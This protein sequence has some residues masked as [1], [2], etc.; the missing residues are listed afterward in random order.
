MKTFG[1]EFSTYD[2]PLKEFDNDAAEFGLLTHTG[3]VPTAGTAIDQVYTHTTNVSALS[4]AWQDTGLTGGT[5]PTGVYL[6]H[7]ITQDLE[8][9]SGTMSW[10]GAATTTTTT[11]EV[12]LHR[13]GQSGT[14]RVYLRIARTLGS[15]KLQM[16]SATAITQSTPYELTFRRLL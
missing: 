3:L 9:Y 12:V 10:F 6:V 15:M 16:A 13:A 11:D 4:S 7:L 1:N 14:N 8:C 2:T 5:M